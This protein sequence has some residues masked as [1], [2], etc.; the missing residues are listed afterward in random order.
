MRL[1]LELDDGTAVT[2]AVAVDTDENATVGEV[3]MEIAAGLRLL[4]IT[5]PSLTVVSRSAQTLPTDVKVAVADLRSGDRVEIV[6]GKAAGKTND[7]GAASVVIEAGPQTGR[8]VNLG[9]GRHYVGRGGR[10]TVVIDDAL[11]SRVHMSLLIS[12]V[13]E[14]SDEGST[15]GVLIDGVVVGRPVVLKRG[16]RV[17][18]GETTFRVEQHSGALAAAANGTLPFNR[19]PRV[20]EPFGGVEVKL[21]TPPGPKPKQRI[22]K[23]A[24][25]FPLIMG[26]TMYAFTRNPQSVLFTALSPL[27]MFGSVMESRKGGAKDHAEEVRLFRQDL[28][29]ASERLDGLAEEERVSREIESP[30]VG[31]LADIVERGEGRMWERSIDDDDF[32]DVRLGVGELPLRSTVRWEPPQRALPELV[33]ECESVV[34]SFAQM[35]S[36]PVVAKL[37]DVVEIGI[38]GAETETES[39]GRSILLQLA[40]LH[41]PAD[42]VFAALLGPQAQARWEWL[43]WLPHVSSAASPITCNHLPAT[44]DDAL[45]LLDAIAQLVEKRAGASAGFGGQE[46]RPTPHVVVMIDESLPL[47]R[48]RMNWLFQLSPAAGISI[49]WLGSSVARMPK[50][51]GVVVD[52]PGGGGGTVGWTSTGR[53]VTNVRFEGVPPAHAA[54]VARSLTPIVDVTAGAAGGSALPMSVS[55]VDVLGTR[56]V[57]HDPNVL[58]ESWGKSSSLRAPIGRSGSGVFT[59]DMRLDGPHALVAGTTGAGKS[60]TLQSLIASLACNHSPKKVTFLLVDYK[61][62]SAFAKCVEFPHTVGMVTDL[63]TN[64]VRRALTSLNAELHFREKLLEKHRCK[65]LIEM[66][67]KGI[68]ETPPSLLIVVD[69][70]A[71]LAKE[72]PEFVDGVVNVAQRGR[73]LGLHL[74]LA[75]QRPA[76]VITDNIKANTN[77]RIALRVADTTESS[78]VIGSPIAA[79]LSRTTPG[80]GVAKVG[81]Q[82]LVTF[83]SGYIGGHT[84]ITD[85]TASIN[86]ADIGFGTFRPWQRR[87]AETAVGPNEPNDLARIVDTARRAVVQAGIPEARRPW[88]APLELVVDLFGLPRPKDDGNVVLGLIDD[89]R[90]QAQRPGI[91]NCEKD[92]SLAIFG[93]SGSG[94][95]ATLFAIAASVSSVVTDCPP[96]VYALDFAG[97]S[98]ETIESLPC[99]GSVIASDDHERITRLLSMLKRVI[100]ERSSAFADVRAGSL[101]DYRRLA[102][103]AAKS[104]PR[105]FILLD[106]YSNFLSTYER[107][108]RGVWADLMPKLIAE[109][110]AVGIHFV[111]TAD[112]RNSL[113]NNV[114][115]LIPQRIVLRMSNDDE[116]GSVGAPYKVLSSASPAGRALYEG[117]ELQVAVAGGSARTDEQSLALQK[118]GSQ[119]RRQRPGQV[120]PPIGVL[121]T[122][123]RRSQLGSALT[124]AFATSGVSLRPIEP[125]FVDGA[126]IVAGPMSSGKTSALVSLGEALREA[127]PLRDIVFCSAR[128]SPFASHPAWTVAVQGADEVAVLIR[129]VAEELSS[130]SA[131]AESGTPAVLIDDFHDLH[132]GDV[133]QAVQALMKVA[134][135][136]PVLVV[137][138]SDSSVARR[139]SQYTALGELR[140]HKQGVIL[141]P[142]VPNGDGDIVYAALPSTSTSVW[143]PGRGYLARRGAAELVHVGLPS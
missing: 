138:T 37:R 48:A 100:N 14:V 31:A 25:V 93:T 87:I 49:I 82:E 21:P 55:L 118:L 130:S 18:I 29:K 81:P 74:I 17:T 59:I 128:R 94:K 134:R 105:M 122:E 6:A 36:A 119:L 88:L 80:R 136:H 4:D 66:E 84:S 129:Q 63:D 131:D 32:L 113:P 35:R 54:R 51:C 9:P 73:S 114:Y 141:C 78:D 24:A 143:P 5:N 7:S 95:S 52:A 50:G 110:R 3:A 109:G 57:L 39:V 96:V 123:T 76:G 20:W 97:R 46:N 1:T 99:V 75:T 41:S 115:S 10:S 116:Y 56:D 19:P 127:N 62:G 22:P 30:G 91:W 86:I 64:Q 72:V 89:P 71:A 47:D 125:P 77:L 70:F 79:S 101:T 42:L 121:E 90:H 16:Q 61:G 92:G 13:V 107:I 142:D 68:E 83:Q 102:P 28:A 112:R 23:A 108:E 120:A 137:V 45:Q 60:E 27:M 44:V 133:G 69:E 65:D 12:D 139:A 67:K 117:L 135:E 53:R 104:C 85:T 15:N 98:L 38:A 103:S 8:R 126:V 124:G 111:V 26:G 106:G 34:Q 43:M 2:R 11:L 132:E 33:S 140:Q 58:I 40:A